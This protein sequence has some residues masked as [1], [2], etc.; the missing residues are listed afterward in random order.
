MSKKKA[1]KATKATRYGVT[2]EDFV[3]AWST[4]SSIDEVMEKTNL[5]KNAVYSRVNSYRHKG[6]KLKRMQRQNKVVN[7]DALNSI[8]TA[9]TPKK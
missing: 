8:V 1:K 3:K 6:V 7:V 4:S 9:N 2:P 5:P